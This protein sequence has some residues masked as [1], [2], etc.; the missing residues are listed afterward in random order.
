MTHI[1]QRI[2]SA[3]LLSERDWS[4]KE[5]GNVGVSAGMLTISPV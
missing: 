3:V 4:N 5:D 1:Y 2:R